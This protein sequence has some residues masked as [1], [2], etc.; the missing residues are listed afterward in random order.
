MELA[1]DV[2]TQAKEFFALPLEKKNEVST[3]LRPNE[4]TGY[5][6]VGKYNSNGWKYCDGYEAFNWPYDA[7]KDPDFPDPSL[8]QNGLWPMD[9]PQFRE[10]LSAYQSAMTRLGRQM[11]R[12]FALALHVQEDAFDDYVQRPEAGVRILHYPK[13]KISRDEQNGIGA[14]TDTNTFTM[15]VA[16][17][18]G[19]EVFSKTSGRW[20]K[21]QPVKNSFVINIADCFMR[22]TVRSRVDR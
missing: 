22:Q 2:L 14:H 19:L 8:P 9:M 13:Q 3:E 12:M 17:D 21:V 4:Y 6:S 1:R 11:T 20:I 5:H 18:E 15:V 10:K 7:S 16:E